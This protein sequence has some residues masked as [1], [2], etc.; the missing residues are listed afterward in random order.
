[1]KWGRAILVT[2]FVI[3]ST[4]SLMKN[5][6]TKKQTSEILIKEVSAPAIH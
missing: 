4:F 6:E 1:M 3:G 5:A 2:I